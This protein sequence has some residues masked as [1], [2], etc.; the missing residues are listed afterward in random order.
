M[1]KKTDIEYFNFMLEKIEDL[2]TYI[3]RFNKIS[4]MLNDNM[5]KDASLMC[6]L[7]V[8]KTLNTL[9]YTYDLLNKEDIQ[10]AYNTRN[11]IAHD[12]EGVHLARIENII[13]VHLPKLKQI[14]KQ[15]LKEKIK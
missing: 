7:Q 8:G 9:N 15:I 6:L 14:I 1:S 13:R 2:E 12:Y 4:I 5:A 3:S 11:F 10:G